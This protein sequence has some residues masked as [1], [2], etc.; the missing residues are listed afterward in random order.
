MPLWSHCS[1]LRS[2]APY[3]FYNESNLQ[4]NT[5]HRGCIW[6]QKSHRREKL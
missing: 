1:I 4:N 2:E 5:P 3:N 6:P